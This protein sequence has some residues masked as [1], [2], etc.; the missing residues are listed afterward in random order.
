VKPT[1]LRQSGIVARLSLVASLLFIIP[2]TY[3]ASLLSTIPH[4]WYLQGSVGTSM[5][6]A[7]GDS[8]LET[9]QAGYPDLYQVSNIKSSVAFALEGGLQLTRSSVSPWFSHYDVGLRYQQNNSAALNGTLME[10][11]QPNMVNYDYTYK[12]SSRQLLLM[13]RMDIYTWKWLSPFAE[14]GLG[15]AMH[16][17]SAYNQ[18]ALVDP[19]TDS[20]AFTSANGGGFAYVY[21]LGVKAQV[22]PNLWISLSDDM[23]SNQ[24]YKTGA[25][26]AGTNLQNK[27][28]GQTALLS[29]GYLF[30]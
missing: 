1:T 7:S 25:G 12:L 29:V 13:G 18:T 27:V 20:Q 17:V 8:T 28:S 21:G 3:A 15:Y 14:V 26:T 23:N 10:Y 16:S 22:K 2:S 6:K 11:S 30:N 9:A 5:Q 4:Q 24:T 19:A